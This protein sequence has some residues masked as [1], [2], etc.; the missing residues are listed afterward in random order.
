MPKMAKENTSKRGKRITKANKEKDPNI[1][2]IELLSEVDSEEE[3]IENKEKAEAD[4]NVD[5]LT[6]DDVQNLSE[7]KVDELAKEAKTAEVETTGD[8]DNEKQVKVLVLKQT[9]R[10]LIGTAFVD[11]L[12][13]NTNVKLPKY[14]AEHLQERG[15]VRIL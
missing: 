1:E 15:R 10:F 3:Y 7:A 12:D 5:E 9:E 2:D 6:T 4:V 11:E 8:I 13:E 14:V